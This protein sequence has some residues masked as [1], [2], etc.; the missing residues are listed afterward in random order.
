MPV[1]TLSAHKM[2]VPAGEGLSSLDLSMLETTSSLRV[3][4]VSLNG[5]DDALSPSCRRSCVRR[6]GIGPCLPPLMTRNDYSLCH[7]FCTHPMD[8]GFQSPARKKM[9]RKGLRLHLIEKKKKKRKK[10]EHTGHVFESVSDQ[11]S[12]GVLRVIPLQVDGL[13]VGL[14]DSETPWGTGYLGKEEGARR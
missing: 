5:P 3:G 10:A 9:V 11:D 14:S 2:K 13:Q 6:A 7:A 4:M 1:H 8:G 12:I